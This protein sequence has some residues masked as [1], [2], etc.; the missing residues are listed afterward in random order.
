M[1]ELKCNK[2]T[3]TRVT[4]PNFICISNAEYENVLKM[5]NASENEI[6]FFGKASNKMIEKRLIDSKR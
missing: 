4:F 6:C 2:E 3:Q 5:V 1:P